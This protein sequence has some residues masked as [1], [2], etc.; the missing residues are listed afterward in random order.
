MG[1][2]GKIYDLEYAYQTGDTTLVKALHRN[3]PDSSFLVS[4]YKDLNQK[5]MQSWM[6]DSI[7]VDSIN[8]E[9]L[10][11]LASNDPNKLGAV[12]YNAMTMLGN[13]GMDY[14]QRSQSISKN[15]RLAKLSNLAIVFPN[16]SQNQVQLNMPENFLCEV[17]FTLFDISG[18]SKK[19]VRL[20]FEKNNTG[21]IDLNELS[22]GIYLYEIECSNFKQNS[23]VI[24]L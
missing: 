10:H 16:P 6:R 24:K 13:I 5:Y 8:V 11:N 20:Y 18:R 9:F 19:N 21:T 22:S 12:V 2:E 14:G 3:F 1:I 17:H 7:E 15:E 23:N 4:L